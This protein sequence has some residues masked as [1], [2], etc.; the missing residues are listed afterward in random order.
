M[1]KIKVKESKPV[2]EQLNI[3][4]YSIQ[5]LQK[6]V[7]MKGFIGRCIVFICVAVFFFAA[8]VFAQEGYLRITSN[9]EGA[10]VELAG[11]NIGKTPLLYAV[12]PGKY[13]YSVS[14][15]G[16]ETI[17]GTIEVVENEVT[18]LN[19]VLTKQI[20]KTPAKP[21]ATKPATAKG[22]LTILTDWQDVT[23]YLNGR[24]VDETPPV[25]L[26]DVPAGLNSVILV[27]GD[28]ADSF[29]ILVQPGKTSVLKKNFE[30]DK[31]KYEAQ[32]I[33]TVVVET[34]VEVIRAKLPAKIVVVISTAVSTEA[35][36][37]ETPIFGE[38]DSIEVSFFYRKTGE[39][40]WNEKTLQSEQDPG[41]A[42]TDGQREPG[43]HK[44]R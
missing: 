3:L 8:V 32:K 38:S 31:K 13:N 11:K 15:S 33:D 39:T 26:K 6:E 29:R 37:Q 36:K 12:K 28:Y 24:K 18:K 16:Y 14:L 20:P 10:G 44:D 42:Y 1:E 35:K 25:T 22:G 2:I 41:L 5:K 21:S 17:S 7:E 4:S 9:P 43:R 27:S 19:F 40:Q 34:P 30:E 23:I